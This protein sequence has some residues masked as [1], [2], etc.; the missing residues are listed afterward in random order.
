V[1]SWTDASGTTTLTYDVQGNLRAVN[2]PN[3]DVVEYIVDGRNRRIGR[4]VNGGLTHRWLYQDQLRP[5]AELDANGNIAS[6]FVYG[7]RTAAPEYLIK[8]G[9]TYRVITDHIGS[10]RL[11]VNDATG[12]VAQRIDYDPWGLV[13]TDTNPGFQPFGFAGGVYDSVSGLV[14]FG[15]RDYDPNVG[16]W[17]SKD[18][19]RFGAA[20]SGL[21]SYSF[22]NPVNLSDPSG[23]F[24]P[25][26]AVPYIVGA[27]TGAISGGVGAF[28][29]GSSSRQIAIAVGLGAIAGATIVGPEL[30]A[31]YLAL[32][33]GFAD[34]VG[35]LV[36][37]ADPCS[38]G[39]FSIA[40]VGASAA[41]GV[42]SAGLAAMLGSLEGFAASGIA[43]QALTTFSTGVS[44]ALWAPT[45]AIL[46]PFGPSRNR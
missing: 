10:V 7:A 29:Q 4:K 33:N 44:T 28:I 34:A 6:R 11:L 36:S 35:Q 30:T 8:S 37:L 41:A 27:V 26:V 15:A 17:L 46:D 43:G 40:A 45:A 24:V 5:I 25:A 22:S 21:Y 14:R 1:Q 18:P 13:Q 19:T 16:R 20:D 9:V 31:G 42:A 39:S 2:L 23:L 32:S 12:V 3:G 38:K